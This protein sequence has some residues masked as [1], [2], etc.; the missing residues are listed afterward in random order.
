MPQ[1]VACELIKLHPARLPVQG[2][3]VGIPVIPQI[4]ISDRNFTKFAKNVL[5]RCRASL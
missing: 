1:A 4:E 2:R 5:T 3:I